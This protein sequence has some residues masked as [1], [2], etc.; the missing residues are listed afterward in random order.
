M[1]TCNGQLTNNTV[2]IKFP[3]S[4]SINLNKSETS[5]VYVIHKNEV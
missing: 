1:S 3:D 2:A 4:I 5:T